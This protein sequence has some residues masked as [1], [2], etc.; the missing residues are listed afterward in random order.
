LQ[1]F[2]TKICEK[3]L[4]KI[5]NDKKREIEKGKVIYLKYDL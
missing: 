2:K 3:T 5:R 1:I 4:N